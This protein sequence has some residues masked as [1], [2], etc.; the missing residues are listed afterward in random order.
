MQPIR[1]FRQVRRPKDHA[2]AGIRLTDA[3]LA[4]GD[5]P[6]LRNDFP[7][8]RK[9]GRPFEPGAPGTAGPHHH[10]FVEEVVGGTRRQGIDNSLERGL[11]C[12]TPP[13]LS[14]GKLGV[15]AQ[16]F[17]FGEKVHSARGLHAT[18]RGPSQKILDES[19]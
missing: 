1:S 19:G 9:R 3:D 15:D 4:F 2:I 14:V 8:Q 17:G 7:P 12:R 5:N 16:L 13:T 11:I 18:G 6:I 10:R